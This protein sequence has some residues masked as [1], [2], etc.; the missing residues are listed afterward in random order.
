[1]IGDETVSTCTDNP[2]SSPIKSI[3]GT[4]CIANGTRLEDAAPYATALNPPPRATRGRESEQLFIL[5]DLTGPASPHLYRELREVLAQT[6]WAT[7]G[8]ITAALRQAATAANRYLFDNNLHSVPSD[9]CY[10]G[11][12]CAALHD[13]DLFILQAGSGRACFLHRDRLE[14][15][16]H[17]KELTPLGMG[18]LANVRLHHAFIAPGNTLLLA[19]SALIQEAGGEAIA[20]VL[21]RAGVHEVLEG[22]EQVGAGADFAALVVRWALPEKVPVDR[23]APPQPPPRPSRKPPRP[24]PRARPKPTRELGPSLGERM[25]KVI[26]SI[27]RG[28][29][30][31]L[32]GIRSVGHGIAAAGVWLARGAGTLFRRMLPGPERETRRRARPP[33]PVPRENRAVMMAIAIGI[34]VVLAI[35]VALAYPSFGAKSRFQEFLNQAEEEIALAQAAGGI[36]EGA[37]PHWEAA[38]EHANT[39]ATLRPD[40][41]VATALQAQAQAAIDFLDGTIRLR[42]VQLEDFGPG[43]MPRQLVVHG[44]KIFVLDPIG[45]WVTQVT[46]N[47]TGDG[48]IEQ[49]DVPIL[50]QTGQQIGGG[51][52]GNLVDF[53][54][55]SLEGGRQ[56]SG[57]L[58]LEEDGALVSYDPAWESEGGAP[59]LQRSFLGT[60]P[61][62]PKVV[63]S[64]KGRLYVLDTAI[65][66]IRRYEPRGDTYPER[67]AHY[68]VDSDSLP[69][70]LADARDI[71]ID[72]S[73]YILYTDGAILKFLGGAPEPFDVR[74]LPGDLSQAVALAVDPDGSSGVVY[75]ADQ[76]NRRVV[77][78][79]PDGVFRAQ[80][81]AD[82]AFDALEALAVDETSRR[83][84]VIS[85]GR[86]YVA[87][88]P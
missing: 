18:R 74:G 12:I 53:T 13:D 28:I 79:G 48:V 24:K 7:T 59:Q 34:P 39:A 15:F 31:I 14:C 83:L 22:L 56:T 30:A 4:L 50:V 49:G 70:S 16:S 78:L 61:H 66:Q 44:Q 72:G 33:R 51:E 43:T 38:L 41:P 17:G 5:L 3:V 60:P 25:G 42:P 32:A 68:F 58:I 77:A 52:V 81:R 63:G 6:Y 36:S 46:L 23:E 11:I 40:D 19:P 65:Q 10:S 62:S 84:Y 47:P 76:G 2:A 87:S 64:F 21:P 80:F 29:S 1:M 9:R 20:R 85:G 45:G 82:G 8:S 54:W 27:G 35:I 86:L 69:R 88:L 71:A 57:L 73:I 67:P 75:V 37:R 26:R 55:V